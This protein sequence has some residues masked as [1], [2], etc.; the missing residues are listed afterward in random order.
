MK[1]IN[2]V[3]ILELINKF[4][5][6][7]YY[8]ILEMDTSMAGAKMSDGTPA[9]EQIHND[10]KNYSSGYTADFATFL[11]IAKQF[12]DVKD[13]YVVVSKYPHM[14]KKSVKNTLLILCLIL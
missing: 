9:F 13:L 8:S 10:I 14:R 12:N 6:N 5:P 4:L 2:I 7:C 11:N 1:E 3:E